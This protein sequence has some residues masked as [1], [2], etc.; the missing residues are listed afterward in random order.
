M[1]TSIAIAK[2]IALNGCN[3]YVAMHAH[4]GVA[5]YFGYIDWNNSQ[6]LILPIINLYSYGHFHWTTQNESAKKRT[7]WPAASEWSD[8]NTKHFDRNH[9]C[10]DLCREPNTHPKS[11]ALTFVAFSIATTVV[12]NETV[13]FS[14]KKKSNDLFPIFLSPLTVNYTVS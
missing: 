14:M 3:K 9:M 1:Q 8:G 7:A 11:F 12:D 5:I 2:A 6:S 4:R 10:I 13:T